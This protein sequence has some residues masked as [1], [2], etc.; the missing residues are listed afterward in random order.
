MKNRKILG[1]D[2]ARNSAVQSRT[3]FS[4][5]VRFAIPT[6]TALAFSQVSMAAEGMWTMDNL[7]LAKMQAEYGYKPNAEWIKKAMLGSARLAFGCS[8]SFVSKEGLVMTNHHCAAAC[9]EQ[10][11]SEKK[12]YLADGFISKNHEEEQRCP[13]MEVNRLEEIH[14][15]TA[16]VKKATAGLSGT[17]FKQAQNAIRAKLTSACVGSDKAATRCDLV[18]LYHG[19]IA[20]PMYAWS[21]HQKNLSPSLVVIQTTSTSHALI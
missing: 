1:A 21:L 9:I 13:A 8:G 5:F 10:I 17:A 19:A 12:N 7:P 20:T 11:S 2:P 14:D 15:V 3:S 4:T 6:L 18:D 16:E